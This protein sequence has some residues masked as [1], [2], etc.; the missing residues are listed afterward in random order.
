[1]NRFQLI[2]RQLSGVLGAA[3]TLAMIFLISSL[4]FSILLIALLIDDRSILLLPFGVA[5]LVAAAGLLRCLI[6][7]RG[8]EHRKFLRFSLSLGLV[9]LLRFGG[10]WLLSLFY[11]DWWYT[12]FFLLD[13]FWGIL[14]LLTTGYGLGALTALP[15]EQKRLEGATV[16]CSILT[17]LFLLSALFYFYFFRIDL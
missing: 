9:L 5:A 16:F 2:T 3:G 4:P 10:G 6:I 14:L 11:T 8:R 15:P 17:V 13:P 12:F 1:M 7:G